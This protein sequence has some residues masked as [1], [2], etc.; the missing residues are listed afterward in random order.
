MPNLFIAAQGKVVQHCLFSCL[1]PCALHLA[2]REYDFK[3]TARPKNVDFIIVVHYINTNISEKGG[4]NLWMSNQ[5]R[6]YLAG[7]FLRHLQLPLLLQPVRMLWPNQ[8]P[9]YLSPKKLLLKLQQGLPHQVVLPVTAVKAIGWA[10]PRSFLMPISPKTI[11]VDVLVLGGGHAGLLA[12]LGASDNGAKVAVVE[13]QAEKAFDGYWGRVG[14]DIGHVNSK[15]LIKR[16]YGPYDTGEITAEFV[17]RAAGR[18]NPDIIRLF[19]ENS[20]PMFD[21][22]VEVYE[23]YKDLRKA[24]DS[25]VEFKYG[26]AGRGPA[27][28]PADNR[29]I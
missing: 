11:D 29:D 25:K 28:P 5:V 27:M 17:K 19:V 12:A 24:N 15:W 23:E 13:K 7:I 10:L 26:D 4:K 14:E 9:R 18:C 22:M 3:N 2:P 1:E 16:G 20:G 8:P 6:I 21:R